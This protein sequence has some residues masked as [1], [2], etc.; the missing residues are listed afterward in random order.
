MG[1]HHNFLLALFLNC[2]SLRLIV[3]QWLCPLTFPWLCL[4]KFSTASPYSFISLCLIT[5]LWIRPI[6][7]LGL[8]H[9]LLRP[10]LVTLSCLCAVAFPRLCHITSRWLCPHNF[11]SLCRIALPWLCPMTF[12][13]LC[14]IPFPRFDRWLSI[15]LPITFHCFTP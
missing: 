2:P 11:P 14:P 3:F 5:F 9:H 4:R 13:R 15:A 10:C 8:H 1:L 7:A 6:A 12:P